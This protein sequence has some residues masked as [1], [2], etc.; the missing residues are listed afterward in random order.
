MTW[1]IALALK[2]GVAPRFAKAAAFAALALALIAALG[3]AKCAYDRS[4]IRK[5]DAAQQLKIERDKAAQM[6]RERA[7][8]ASLQARKADD[9]KAA[10]LRRQEIDH[11]T[12]NIPDQAPSPRQRA[13]ACLSLRAQAKAAGQ[14][15]PAC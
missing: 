5:H 6:E 8:D 12:R 13:R 3:T 7:A 11:A 14:P 1:L 4:V 2:A 9:I 10:A 15:D